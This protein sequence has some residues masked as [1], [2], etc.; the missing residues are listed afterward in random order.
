M[1]SAIIGGISLTIF[2]SMAAA[3]L[4]KKANAD[5][6]LLEKL[7]HFIGWA[8]VVYLYFRFWYAFSMTYTYEPGR[9]EGLAL[10]TKGPLAFNFWVGEI[11]LGAVVPMII[12]LRSKWRAD[13][14]LRM[15]ALLMV[16]GGLVAYR[17]DVNLSGQLVILSYLP[18][19]IETM[20]TT[21]KPALIEWMVGAGVVAFGLMA[22]TLGVQ[23]LGI[24]DHGVEEEITVPEPTL[25]A[26]PIPALGD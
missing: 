22:F 9:T 8:L 17:W 18:K 19:E 20:Y 16:V 26:E 4:S 5:D 1:T 10:L 23:Y 24:V 6:A 7:A 21:Y 14:R 3:R 12:L 15:L 11:L 2:A 13:P 25:E